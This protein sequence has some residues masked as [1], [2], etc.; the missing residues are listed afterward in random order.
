VHQAAPQVA[1]P[2]KIQ[3]RR[4]GELPGQAPTAAVEGAEV[5]AA[6]VQA[7]ETASAPVSE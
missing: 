6:E 4:A 3:V 1:Q 7:A 5:P 2:I